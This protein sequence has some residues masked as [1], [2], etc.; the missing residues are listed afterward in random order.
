MQPDSIGGVVR[1]PRFLAFAC[2]QTVSQFG[3]KLDQMALVAILGTLGTGPRAAWSLAELAVVVA[4]PVILFGPV[5]GVLVDRW[6]RR[7][8]LVAGDIIRGALVASIPLAHR[9]AGLWPIYVIV[10]L[11]FRVTLV[12]NAAKMAVVPDLVERRQLLAANSLTTSLGRVATVAGIVLGGLVIDWSVW[13]RFGWT[14][15]EAAFY[16]D[17]VSFVFSA[18]ML[19]IAVPA[20]P[21]ARRALRAV[22][23][24]PGGRGSPDNG[25][26][27]IARDFG[28]AVRLVRSDRGL[29]FVFTTIALIAAS[30]GAGY[31]VLVV[32]I[33]TILAFG[34]SGLGVIGGMGAGGMVLGS[35]LAGT[36]VRRQPRRLVIATGTLALGL[37]VIAFANVSTFTGAAV[38]AMLV[39]AFMAPIVIAQ[40]TWLQEALPERVR[41]RGFAIRELLN[42][43]VGAG[44]SVL[45]AGAVAVFGAT[46]LA[47]P[48]RATLVAIG[49][50][51]VAATIA[52]QALSRAQVARDKAKECPTPEVL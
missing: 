23:T 41:G 36:V 40:D 12:S 21:A 26:R 29:T 31:V 10:F 3:D 25:V 4:L 47:D 43:A 38:A 35:L 7:A 48:Y 45:G 22:R 50:T 52:L 15:Y 14:G 18:L 19:A 20:A 16:L 33:Q 11:V 1:A 37:L 42:N 6:D 27:R 51:V 8:T 49:L 34:A 17:G 39:G 46:G 28:E 2:G 44:G 9:F 5:A 13:A 30:V 24:A 32:L